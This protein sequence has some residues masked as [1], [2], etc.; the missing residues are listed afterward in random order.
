MTWHLRPPYHPHF[1][2]PS[3][4]FE[5]PR[6]SCTTQPLPK[7]EARPLET[8]VGTCMFRSNQGPL[9]P[10]PLGEEV[11][12]EFSFCLQSLFSQYGLGCLFASGCIF[13]REPLGQRI[14]FK[15]RAGYEPA[16]PSV[17]EIYAAEW[18][19]ASPRLS[20]P[21]ACFNYRYTYWVVNRRPGAGLS[22]SHHLEEEKKRRGHKPVG[23]CQ[24]SPGPSYRLDKVM[25]EVTCSQASFSL[26]SKEQA[27]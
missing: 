17:E 22:A 23:R 1:N 6:L 19:V 4:Q 3:F 25:D 5:F 7:E 10:E 26:L 16:L 21:A 20:H 27:R 11:F 2:P 24:T 13:N 9:F 14:F 15:S 18:G 8:L 12:G